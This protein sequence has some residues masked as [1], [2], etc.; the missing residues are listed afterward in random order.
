MSNILFTRT[1]F[2]FSWGSHV[3]QANNQDDLELLV[4]T[5][6]ERKRQKIKSKAERYCLTTALSTV[7]T[8]LETFFKM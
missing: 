1:T 4:S 3:A 7:P 2:S 5:P 8:Q 6:P